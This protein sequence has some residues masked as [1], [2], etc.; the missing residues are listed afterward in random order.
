MENYRKVKRK[1]LTVTLTI[2]AICLV[3][4]IILLIL[5]ILNT[6]DFGITNLMTFGILPSLSSILVSCITLF[7]FGCVD[8]KKKKFYK[9]KEQK[10]PSIINEMKQNVDDT[11]KFIEEKLADFKERISKLNMGIQSLDIPD[12]VEDDVRLFEDLKKLCTEYLDFVRCLHDVIYNQ[13]KTLDRGR[14][15]SYGKYIWVKSLSQSTISIIKQK[16]KCEL[17]EK[18]T[19]LKEKY[20]EFYDKVINGITNTRERCRIISL[21]DP[22]KYKFARELLQLQ[23]DRFTN[24]VRISELVQDVVDVKYV[25]G[26]ESGGETLE[27]LMEQEKREN[28]VPSGINDAVVDTTPK[29]QES[30]ENGNTR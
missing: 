22:N 9:E 12:L 14:Y 5:Q 23:V 29:Q 16:F 1:V 11:G 4:T 28:Q 6:I 21:L 10:I 27:H 30:L 19:K 25:L 3:T 24:M 15:F 13:C 2:T 17:H 26:K 7:V 20:N 18:N 8:Y